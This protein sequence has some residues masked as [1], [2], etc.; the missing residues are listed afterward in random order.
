MPSRHETRPASTRVPGV[1]WDC[2]DRGD[3]GGDRLGRASSGVLEFT[4][5]DPTWSYQSLLEIVYFILLAIPPC[6]TPL[7][8]ALVALRWGHRASAG[9]RPARRPGHLA[10]LITGAGVHYGL[11]EV[12]VWFDWIS[13]RGH[14][15]SAFNLWIIS[16]P[17]G[18]GI[19]VGWPT[20]VLAGAWRPLP[21]WIDRTGRLVGAI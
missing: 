13:S 17:I 10:C 8:L 15:D 6:V 7:A 12:A 21:D 20:L 1:G 11:V 9:R 18:V 4:L 14:T 5:G 2:P 3:R 16:L 19:L